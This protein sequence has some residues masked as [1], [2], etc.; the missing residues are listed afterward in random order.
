MQMLLQEL[1]WDFGLSL[2]TEATRTREPPQS[3]VTLTTVIFGPCGYVTF[4]DKGTLE[5]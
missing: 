3:N 1:Q 2:L 4:L 5:V